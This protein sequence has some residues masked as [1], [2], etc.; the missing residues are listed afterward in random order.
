MGNYCTYRQHLDY[1]IGYSDRLNSI[2]NK[3]Y[4]NYRKVHFRIMYTEMTLVIL[5]KNK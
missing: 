3:Y 2:F 5:S 4:I 1:I